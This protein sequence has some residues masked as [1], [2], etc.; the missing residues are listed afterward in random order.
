[1]VLRQRRSFCILFLFLL[2][3]FPTFTWSQRQDTIRGASPELSDYYVAYGNYIARPWLLLPADFL[4]LARKSP[5]MQREPASVSS[6]T[7]APAPTFAITQG[8]YQP[9]IES[10]TPYVQAGATFKLRD[11][12]YRD[13][14][15]PWLKAGLNYIGDVTLFGGGTFLSTVR[16]HQGVALVGQQPVSR[17]SMQLRGIEYSYNQQYLNAEATFYYQVNRRGILSLFGGVGTMAG[18]S[19]AGRGEIMYRTITIVTDSIMLSNGT[20]AAYYQERSETREIDN[21]NIGTGGSFGIFLDIGVN[22]RLGDHYRLF[23][24]LYA[25]GEF[26][27][28]FKL[29]LIPKYGTN[30]AIVN[31]W[32]AGIR[33]QFD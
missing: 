5:P 15:G 16:K 29:D 7:F 3:H 22:L 30:T 14:D 12:E 8:I 11:N 17:D 33:Y 27:P 4:P 23:K 9:F 24:H 25:F 21:V 31:I 32:N 26:K 6:G 1:M 2:L 10:V 28:V 20:T 18:V 13:L 19:F